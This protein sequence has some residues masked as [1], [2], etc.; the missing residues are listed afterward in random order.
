MFF[1]VK[2]GYVFGYHVFTSQ[3]AL[4]FIINIQTEYI[5]NPNPNPMSCS[6][7]QARKTCYFTRMTLS[8]RYTEG[9]N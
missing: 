9:C 5:F 6:F 3:M 8:T 7:W 1:W 4:I 2:F